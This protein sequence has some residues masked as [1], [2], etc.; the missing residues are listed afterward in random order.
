MPV[1]FI[2]HLRS[3]QNKKS[4][5]LRFY[6]RRRNCFVEWQGKSLQEYFVSNEKG[7]I[8]PVILK[9]LHSSLPKNVS[10]LAFTVSVPTFTVMAVATD[11]HRTSLLSGIA[12]TVLQYLINNEIISQQSSKVNITFLFFLNNRIFYRLHFQIN[13]TL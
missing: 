13:R 4:V 12:R 9:R 7:Q 5:F 11:L 6:R 10:C 1:K 3:F 8:Y 2:A